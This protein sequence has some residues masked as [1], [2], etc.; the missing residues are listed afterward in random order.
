MIE[1][2]QGEL[3]DIDS[4]TS[5]WFTGA[6][7]SVMSE[8]GDISDEDMMR[9]IDMQDAYKEAFKEFYLEA[10]KQGDTRFTGAIQADFDREYTKK[11]PEFYSFA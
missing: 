11:V 4:S 2:T 8:T 1:L 10:K 5:A 6:K 7:H 9:I 3:R